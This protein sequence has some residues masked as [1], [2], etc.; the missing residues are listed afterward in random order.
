MNCPIIPAID[1]LDG[2]VVRLT[3]G[4]YDKVEFYEKTPVEFAKYFVDNGIKRIHL[5]DLD[6]AKDG[7]LVNRHV[8]ESI[9][10]N[11]SCELELG[12]GIRTHDNAKALLDIGINYLILGSL[13]IKNFELAKTIIHQFPK[14]IIAGI[15][16]KDN[17]VS[18]EGW[19]EGSQQSAETLLESLEN[20]PLNSIIYT[21]IAKDGTLEG[22]N[23]EG[24]QNICQK[25]THPVIASGGIGCLE[26]I[27]LIQ[28]LQL[29]QIQGIIVGK[30]IL[31]GKLSL[32]IK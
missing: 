24:L 13:L 22:P 14:Q 11:V 17:K 30:A 23:I 20:L 29:K 18:I 5:V 8:F 6:G 19:L 7:T 31:S 26:D 25:T 12:G 10:K 21:D 16:T 1:I 15:D 32:P 3:Q 28:N 2:R 27:Q 4:R 9:R